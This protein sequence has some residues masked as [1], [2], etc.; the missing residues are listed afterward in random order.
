LNA[1]AGDG[2]VNLSWDAGSEADGYFVYRSLV[3][4][5]GY[6]RLNESPLV[7]TSFTDDTV[8][9]GRL[10]Y[11]VV[12]AVDATGNESARSNE[13]QALPY[14]PVGWA[15]HLWPPAITMTIN[16]L[17]PQTVYA[18]VWVAG[19]TDAPG[20]GQG[21][22]AQFAYG[23]D[24][25][26]TATWDWAAMVYNVDVG[27]NDEYMLSFVP[28]SLGTFDY[29]ARFST[30]LGIDWTYAYTDEGQVGS[31]VVNPSGDAVP[32]AV[33]A[34]LRLE[35]ASPSFITLAWEPVAD[36]DLY[37]YEVYRADVSGGPYTK[38]ANVLAP[39]TAYTDWSVTANA[40]YYYV[41]LATDTSFNR[42]AYSN[43]LQATAQPRQ[44]QV[45]FNAT[46]PETTP[47]GDAIYMGGSFNGWDPAGT[48]MN[49]TDLLA[50]VTLTFYEGDHLEYKYTRGSWTY[51]EKG[52]AC[53]EVGNRVVNVVY[54]AEG[55]MVVNDTVLNWR[56]TGSCGD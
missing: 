54:G 6:E 37:R 30:N 50:T 1:I 39:E 45:T 56:N 19:V 7:G 36:G 33:P 48:L 10:Y 12:T 32:P 53:E 23:P 18:Q 55:M 25:S 28:E 51:V 41:V 35:E 40:T 4:G 52:A 34:N 8:T 27:N 22:L 47:P 49:R 17:D 21:I 13:A 15:G 24:G 26:D 11:Y 29:L 31:L 43:E 46:L 38:L 44:V 42:S 5:G 16:A 3:S 14:T 2:Y 9:N 20:Q